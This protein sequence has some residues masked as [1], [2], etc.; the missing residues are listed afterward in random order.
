MPATH[1]TNIGHILL[2]VDPLDALHKDVAETFEYARKHKVIF[3]QADIPS[4][5]T[6]CNKVYS[7]LSTRMVQGLYAVEKTKHKL[8]EGMTSDNATILLGTSSYALS[9][10]CEIKD[11]F[12][13]AI[14]LSQLPSCKHF[15]SNE[16]DLFEAAIKE[17]CDNAIVKQLINIGA[18]AKGVYDATT[19][20]EVLMFYRN[21][22]RELEWEINNA[23]WKLCDVERW[24]L[25]KAKAECG[26]CFLAL[27]KV[28]YS[29][30]RDIKDFINEVKAQNY[31]KEFEEKANAL[32]QQY[33]FQPIY[34]NGSGLA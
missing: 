2:A 34:K 26:Y 1:H 15:L 14:P 29:I 6:F 24:L 27:V 16:N 19:I 20:V 8:K 21:I 9:V 7:I 17:L 33:T 23:N 10:L 22:V 28:G 25:D 18:I 3:N 31:I 11:R 12:S 30:S 13:H 4:Q 5:R 32:P